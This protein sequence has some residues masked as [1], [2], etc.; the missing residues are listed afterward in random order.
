VIIA[1][2]WRGAALQ[3]GSAIRLQPPKAFAP[4]DLP[5]MFA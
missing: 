2:G 1:H 5:S 3:D 4:R